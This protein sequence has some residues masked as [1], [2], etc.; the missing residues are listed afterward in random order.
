MRKSG[1]WM[2]LVDDRILETLQEEGFMTPS[3]LAEQ[4]AIRYSAQHVGDR[5]RKLAKHD[6]VENIGNGVYRITERGTKYLEGE[7]NTAEDFSDDYDSPS[8]TDEQETTSEETLI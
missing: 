7:I 3:D 2:V 1:R 5:C 4:E 8:E 6:L